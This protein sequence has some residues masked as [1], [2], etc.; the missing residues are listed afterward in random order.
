MGVH[1]A[2][3]KNDGKDV[4]PPF[5]IEVTYTNLRGQMSPPQRHRIDVSE[6]SGRFLVNAPEVEVADA[7][8]KIEGHLAS[9]RG[10]SNRLLV[11]TITTAER[12][13]EDE[14]F[15]ASR[16][17]QAAAEEAAKESS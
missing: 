15:L 13:V 1:H 16:K 14:A 10:G 9:L 5:S 7:V 6:F 4:L 11:E 2:L 12:R 8:K 17:Q 3:F